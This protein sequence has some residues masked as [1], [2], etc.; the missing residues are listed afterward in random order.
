MK[1]PYQLNQRVRV[2][3]S[4]SGLTDDGTIIKVWPQH[5]KVDEPWCFT[6]RLDKPWSGNKEMDVL[7]IG[8][9]DKQLTPL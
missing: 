4:N 9:S 1:S 2:T 3:D 7:E 8:R 6:I 5:V